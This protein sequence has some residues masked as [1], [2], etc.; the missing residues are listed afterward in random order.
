MQL[1]RNGVVIAAFFAAA[2]LALVQFLAR[3]AAPLTGARDAEMREERTAHSAKRWIFRI[4]A[5]L[6]IA[7]FGGFLFVASGIMPIK[8]S[9]G[10]WAITAWFLNFAM[11]RS[12]VTHSFGVKAPNLD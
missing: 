5:F 11:R 3:G 8:A 4:T 12:V 7:A 1:F 6:L 9:S 10:H 2:V